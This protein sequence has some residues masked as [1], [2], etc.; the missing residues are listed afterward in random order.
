MKFTVKYKKQKYEVSLLDK[1]NIEAIKFVLI[2]KRF[3]RG[4]RR[5]IPQNLI[6]YM[7]VTLFWIAFGIITY[8][9]GIIYKAPCEYTI[10][11]TRFGN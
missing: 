3:V 1:M 10:F 8:N 11:G 9:C 4:A 5:L 6:L 7:W 2:L